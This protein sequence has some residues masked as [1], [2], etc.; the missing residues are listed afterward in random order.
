MSAKTAREYI[1]QAVADSQ[2]LGFSPAASRKIA[3]LNDHFAEVVRA[4]VAETPQAPGPSVR[5]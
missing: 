2:F 3:L 1:N 5:T 4:K